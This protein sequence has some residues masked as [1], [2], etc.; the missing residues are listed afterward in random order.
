MPAVPSALKCRGHVVQ[1]HDASLLIGEQWHAL[2]LVSP[3]EHASTGFNDLRVVDSALRV[4][5]A[6]V[7]L[8]EPQIPVWILTSG[9]QPASTAL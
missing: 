7:R 6:Q 9:T 1:S 3:M 4:L 5:Q 8:K 2:V